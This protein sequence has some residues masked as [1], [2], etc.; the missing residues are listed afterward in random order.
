MNA[1]TFH[2]NAHFCKSRDPF[3]MG[4]CEVVFSSADFSLMQ[5]C[6]FASVPSVTFQKSQLSIVWKLCNVNLL[7]FSWH[8]FSDNKKNK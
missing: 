4:K 8:F 2:I 5:S 6:Y 7:T 3:G 1:V